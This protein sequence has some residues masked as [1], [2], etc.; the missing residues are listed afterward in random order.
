LC[1]DVL[2]N[3]F[4]LIGNKFS[5]TPLKELETKVPNFVWT[6]PDAPQFLM[7]SNPL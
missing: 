5:Y 6:F 2:R 7:M 4:D 1:A 3:D